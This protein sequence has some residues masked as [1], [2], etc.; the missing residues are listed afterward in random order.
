MFFQPIRFAMKWRDF[1]RCSQTR[2]IRVNANWTNGR[3]KSPEMDCSTLNNSQHVQF[4]QHDSGI[5]WLVDGSCGHL[6]PMVVVADRWTAGAAEWATYLASVSTAFLI[7]LILYVMYR[8]LMNAYTGVLG[9][10][11][12]R[13]SCPDRLMKNDH[14]HSSFA[15]HQLPTPHRVAVARTSAIVWK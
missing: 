2:S 14:R 5:V 12:S 15:I 3:G 10:A 11:C 13:A 1:Q 9:P 7:K 6:G 4:C 8:L